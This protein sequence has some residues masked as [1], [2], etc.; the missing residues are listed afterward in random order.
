MKFLDYFSYALV[1]QDNASIYESQES[2]WDQCGNT[3]GSCCASIS[4]YKQDSDTV[5][6]MKQ[7][8]TQDFASASLGFWLDDFYVGVECSEGYEEDGFMM[9]SGAKALAMSSMIASLILMISQ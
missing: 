9:K 3:A 7:C 1:G 8:V 2:C 4:M 6:Y 5:S